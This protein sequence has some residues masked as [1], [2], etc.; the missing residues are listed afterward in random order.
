[1]IP[2]LLTALLGCQGGASDT[3]H[4][5]PC[6]VVG[7][8]GEALVSPSEGEPYDVLVISI[9][10]LRRDRVG[11]YAGTDVSPFLD[12]FLESAI[13]FDDFRSCSNWTLGAMA[14]AQGGQ[15]AIDLGLDIR[16]NTPDKGLPDDTV[17]APVWW[18][19]GGYVTGLVSASPYMSRRYA[20]GAGHDLDASA[21][22]LDAGAIHTAALETLDTLE[23]QAPDA[24][25]MLHLHYVEPHDPYDP[26]EA[27]LEALEDLEPLDW[28]LG[29]AGDV[30]VI[31]DIYPL[32]DADTQALVLQHIEVRYA[33]EIRDLDDHLGRL[34][35]DLEA[36][37]ALEHTVVALF[38]DHGEQFWEHHRF[39][40]AKSLH[41]E[42]LAGIAAIRVPG[43][44]PLRW[45]GP[46][47]T[48]DL[49][50]TLFAAADLPPRD[51]FTGVPVG[52]APAD[53]YRL[54]FHH[55]PEGSPGLSLE[56]DKLRL[57]YD[58]SGRWR[59]FAASTAPPEATARMSAGL[60]GKGCLVERMR[61]EVER[62]AVFVDHEAP[63]GL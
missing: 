43:S 12:G 30:S 8:G 2:L 56:R 61:Q 51:G 25:W 59:L 31:Q 7:Q 11:L 45:E 6:E 20:T 19:E 15:T 21:L 44:E 54:S 33:G 35:D 26:P 18:S 39:R 16:P 10:T 63:Q 48:I 27:Y 62:A 40:H 53:R 28:D 47:S 3:A 38:S 1:V 49:L 9:D 46:V 29:D 36:R 32:L 23:A 58:W 50:P 57:L 22:G 60:P 13:R 41:V 5:T 4:P 37:G 55:S 24:P 34:F 17:L 14:C 52:T 42:E